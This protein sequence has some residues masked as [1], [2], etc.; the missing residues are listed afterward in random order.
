MTVQVTNQVTEQ[1]MERAR[2]TAQVAV[3]RRALASAAIKGVIPNG[4]EWAK[5]WS[6]KADMAALK[7]QPSDLT[8]A[9]VYDNRTPRRKRQ[10][11]A[12]LES[13]LLANEKMEAGRMEEWERRADEEAAIART[14]IESGIRSSDYPA[15][16]IEPYS[17]TSD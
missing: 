17:P 15:H 5:E 14:N 2:L 7:V 3:L 8:V 6:M 16:V 13:A 4:K 12:D 10:D 11:A 1:D 9:R